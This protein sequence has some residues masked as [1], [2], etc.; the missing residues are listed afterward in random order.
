MGRLV[1]VGIAL[2]QM[3]ALRPGRLTVWTDEGEKVNYEK[4]YFAA[5]MNHPYE[6]GGFLFCPEASP[7]DD[8]LDVTVIAGL[9]KWKALFLLPLAFGGKHVNFR[10]V[11]ILTCKKVIFESEKPL[12]VHTDGEP[13]P[14]QSRM[15]AELEKEKVRVI[16]C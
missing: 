4:T 8:S 11:H 14:Y 16:V 7:C 10:G 3:A 1:Y 15:K 13:I 2:S 5:A 12:P 6:G 9:P